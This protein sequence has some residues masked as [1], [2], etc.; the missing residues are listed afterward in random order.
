MNSRQNT[1]RTWAFVALALACALASGGAQALTY[2]YT[3]TNYTHVGDPTN[4]THMTASVTFDG[5]I[6]ANYTGAVYGA[7]MLSWSI[8]SGG[9]T[10]VSS[11]P[12]SGPDVEDT[13][14]LTN[15]Q[16]TSWLFGEYLNN[17]EIDSWNYG[18]GSTIPSEDQAFNSNGSAS[19]ISYTNVSGSWSLATVSAVPEPSGDVVLLAGIGVLGALARRRRRAK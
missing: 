19:Q 13:I 7:D 16:I 18:P 15:G 9:H 1:T 11:S 12:Y 4:G 6:T 5:Y 17:Y 10:F 3:G 8:S 2:D 14:V